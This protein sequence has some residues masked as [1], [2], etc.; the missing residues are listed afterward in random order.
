MTKISCKSSTQKE[1]ASK[2]M[3]KEIWFYSG[4]MGKII[5]PWEWQPVW[6]TSGLKCTD[7]LID[8]RSRVNQLATKTY[9]SF[10]VPMG[11]GQYST[12][13][14]LFRLRIRVWLRTQTRVMSAS[15][16]G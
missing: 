7:F 6:G 8:R 3:Q 15:E 1:E 13:K 12:M 9:S 10:L 5:C 2:E 4:K 14:I 16:L 11:F